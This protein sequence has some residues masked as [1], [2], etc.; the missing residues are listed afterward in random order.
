MNSFPQLVQTNIPFI[1]G[2]LLA[3]VA[4]ASAWFLYRRTVPEISN[5]ARII[6][7]SLRLLLIFLVILLFFTPRLLMIFNDVKKEKLGVFIDNSLSM[8]T[9]TDSVSS[10]QEAVQ[11]AEKLKTMSDDSDDWQ[12]YSFNSVIRETPFDSLKLS[13]GGTNFEKLLAAIKKESLQKAVIISDGNYTEGAYPFVNPWQPDTKI[14]TVGAGRRSSGS[15]IFI[16][17]IDYQPAA[18]QGRKSVIRIEI[19]SQNLSGLVKSRLRL[20][21]GR[22]VLVSRPVSLADQN[23]SKLIELEYVPQNTGLQK[24]TVQLDPAPWESNPLNNSAAVIQDI[25]KSEIKAAV[26]SGQA[27]FESKFINLLLQDEA[28]FRCRQYVE[29]RRGQLIGADKNIPWDSL[30]VLILQDYPGPYTRNNYIQKISDLLRSGEA[31]AVFIFGERPDF[32]RMTSFNSFLPFAKMPAQQNNALL[33]TGY[34]IGENQ[35]TAVLNLF[36]D[37]SL[38]SKFW[39]IIP[40]LTINHTIPPL[41]KGANVLLQAASNKG[42]SPVIIS[43]RFKQNNFFT[44]FGAGFWKWH[45]LLQDKPELQSGYKRLLMNMVR[46]LANRSRLKRVVLETSEKTGNPGRQIKLKAVLFDADFQRLK[47][48]GLVLQARWDKQN[49]EIPVEKDSS[50]RFEAVLIPPGEGRYVITAS[51]YS[52]GSLLGRDSVHIEVIPVEK[53]F[54]KTGQ[55][56]KFLN[57]LAKLGSGWYVSAGGL[58]SLKKVLQPKTILIRKESNIDLWYKPFLLVM[59]ILIAALEWLLRKRWGLV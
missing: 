21:K 48:G 30:D 34:I 15:D 51:G 16:S 59:I 41:K 12:W 42:R 40:P 49:F 10:W 52:K 20:L 4:F 57:K 44:L 53:E 11:L 19:S 1:L 8:Q 13:Q 43:S 5:T 56:V 31:G 33:S 45:F 54:L 24:L 55:N 35:Q 3:A 37:F 58:D 25:L 50:G 39:Q 22:N 18:Y 6:L 28:D 7:G 36:D 17:D 9:E 29:D 2:L 26:F 32:S 23:T 38:N 46:S 14:Y 27:G 47:D